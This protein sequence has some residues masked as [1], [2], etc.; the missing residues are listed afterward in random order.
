VNRLNIGQTILHLR[1][2]KSITQEQLGIMIGVSAGAVSKW[3]TGNSTPDISLLAPLAR[4][5]NTSLDILL[6]FQQELSETEVA[7]IKQELTEIFLHESYALGEAKCQKYL[8]EYPNSMHLKFMVAGLIQMYSMLADNQS[9]EL[10]NEKRQDALALFQQVAA[11]REPK[12][13]SIA[14]FLIANIQMMLGNYAESEEALKQLPETPINPMTLYP[15]LLL[16]QGKTEEAMNLCSRVLL[17][18]INQDYLTLTTMSNIA[19][20]EQNYDRAVLYLDAVYKMQNIFKMGLN[21]AAY[22]FSKLYIETGRNED[23]AKWFKTYVDGL[24]S[25]GYDYN[26]NPYFESIELAVKPEGQ[27]IIRTKLLQSLIDEDDLKVLTGIPEYEEAI[28][29]LRIAIN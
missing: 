27:K 6:S 13:T 28:E 1:K 3:E 8:N 23:A 22:N 4:A 26:G 2:E 11:S 19:K 16:R 17:Q 20:K 24:L 9:E 25:T 18:Y 10:I 14:L 15:T 5:L 29:E 7:R 12:Y 21:S